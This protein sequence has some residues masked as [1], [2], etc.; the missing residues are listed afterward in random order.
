MNL[1]KVINQKQLVDALLVRSIVFTDEQKVPTNIQ[2][3]EEDQ[4]CLHYVCYD[5]NKAIG[6]LRLIIHNNYVK[7]GRFCVLKSHRL[8]GVG[9]FMLTALE[10][11]K[12][13]IEVGEI[14]FNAQI[15]VIKFY[16]SCGYISY[17]DVFEEANIQ[18]KRMKKIIYDK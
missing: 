6:A 3:D 17:G 2:I 16:E 10:K 12:E 7:L 4:T 11:E 15:Q 8:L 9:H 1:I 14:R 18:H 5:N 13:I